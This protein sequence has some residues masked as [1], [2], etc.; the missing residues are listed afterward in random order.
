MAQLQ[1]RVTRPCQGVEVDEHVVACA[2][3]APRLNGGNFQE[4]RPDSIELRHQLSR[5]QVVRATVDLGRQVPLGELE[6]RRAL[7]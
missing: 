2:Q 1:L 4:P 3:V 5:S 7:H 6:S